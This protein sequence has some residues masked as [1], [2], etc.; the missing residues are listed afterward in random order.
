MLTVKGSL[1]AVE[2]LIHHSSEGEGCELACANQP[3]GHVISG[4]EDKLSEVARAAAGMGIETARLNIPFAFHSAQVEPILAEFEQAAAQGVA[5]HPPTVPVL[6]PLLAKTVP[7]GDGDTLN[8]SYLA[9]ACRSKV[10]FMVPS[11]LLLPPRQMMA[12]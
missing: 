8:A 6:S 7:T 5:C 2:Q 4:P 3:S 10:D 12:A 1:E 9:A 11:R